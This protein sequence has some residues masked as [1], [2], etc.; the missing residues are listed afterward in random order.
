MSPPTDHHAR[1][2]ADSLPESLHQAA[3]PS[4]SQPP[5]P[6]PRSDSGAPLSAPR[7]VSHEAGPDAIPFSRPSTPKAYHDKL[8]FVGLGNMGSQMALNLAT[9]LYKDGQPPLLVWNRS[10]ARLDKFRLIVEEKGIPVTIAKDL[11]EVANKCDMIVTSLGSDKAVEEVYGE[12]FA[13][14]EVSRKRPEERCDEPSEADAK[15]MPMG[16]EEE[17]EGGR[18]R[19]G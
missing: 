9:S 1:F 19:P 5:A 2:D 16:G 10:A 12:L 7:A 17:E 13:A 14:T 6:R 4:G 18:I 3:M 8:G 15:V 11:K